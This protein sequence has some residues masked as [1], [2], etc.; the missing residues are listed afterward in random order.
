MKNKWT[1]PF[2]IFSKCFT[3]AGPK[4]LK[5]YMRIGALSPEVHYSCQATDPSLEGQE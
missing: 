1:N 3:V 5:L 2:H 4:N